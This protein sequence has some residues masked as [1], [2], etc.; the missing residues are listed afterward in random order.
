MT[1]S[2]GLLRF[3]LFSEI[4][5]FLWLVYFPGY[6]MVLL[7]RIRLLTVCGYDM[8][9]TLFLATDEPIVCCNQRSSEC[10]FDYQTYRVG[11]EFF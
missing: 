1:T 11:K 10:C 4:N 6:G 2:V 7:K 3:F 8:D 9:G 5:E